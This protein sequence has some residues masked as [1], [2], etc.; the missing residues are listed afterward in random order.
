VNLAA[1]ASD[2]DG[3]VSRVDFYRGT[4]LIGSSTSAPYAYA[5]V[6]VA[7][8]SYSYTAVATDNAGVSTTS[9]AVAVTVTAAGG[10]SLNA[11]AQA[12]GGVA[13]ASSS[14]SANFPAAGA[15]NGDRKGLNWANGGGWND[16][17][18]SSYPDWL[19]VK[20]SSAQSIGEIDVFTVQDNY[21]SPSEPTAAMTFTQYGITS[22]EV[23]YWDGSVWVD[24]PG[25]NV[26]G[27]N[28]VWRKFTFTPV[29]TDRVRV[30]VN[31]A[32]NSYSRITEIE[33]WTQ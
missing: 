8:G 14:Y 33:A 24:V 27:N 10:G 13:T 31:G 29:T 9:S 32:L 16:A 30:L 17:T 7:A 5:D 11:A 25:G 2:S 6:G 22:F 26:T 23:Q 1:T 4:T 18:A 15:N 28:L 12:N 20:F 21:Q 19:Q 3:T